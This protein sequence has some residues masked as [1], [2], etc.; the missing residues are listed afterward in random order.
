MKPIRQYIKYLCTIILLIGA[1][2][3]LQ[4]AST[5]AE[6]NLT[7]A[8]K[9]K[10]T[11]IMIEQNVSFI[12]ATRFYV[13]ANSEHN[14]RE[15]PIDDYKNIIENIY[16]AS[17]GEGDKETLL[18]GEI[19]YTMAHI[20]NKFGYDQFHFIRLGY[21]LGGQK[22]KQERFADHIVLEVKNK[23]TGKYELHDPD[24]NVHYVRKDDKSMTPLSAEEMYLTQDID[25]TVIPVRGEAYGKL[26]PTEETINRNVCKMHCNTMEEVFYNQHFFVA[27]ENQNNGELYFNFPQ[28][29]PDKKIAADF[30][31]W[32]I[33]TSNKKNGI[34][35]ISVRR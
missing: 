28:L 15:S 35:K 11:A 1:C 22:A 13:R 20:L 29:G 2:Y 33:S 14:Y 8:I 9:H 27:A 5:L 32:F 16:K 31:L 18:C 34:L 26:L 3:F 21:V 25:Q 17:Q 10:I 4:T 6:E 7:D 23:D 30:M 24:F 12:E 19:A